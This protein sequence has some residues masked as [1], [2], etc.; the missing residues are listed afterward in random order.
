MLVVK[1]GAFK[2][3]PAALMSGTIYLIQ[4]DNQLIPLAEQPY[5]SEALLQSLLAQHPSLLAGEQMTDESPRRW[6]L[7]SRE[8]PV[9]S[10]DGAASWYVDHLYVDQDA[11]PTLV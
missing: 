11:I 10:E 7:L 3:I 6:L 1:T 9:S 2:T 5:D 4:P 8:T